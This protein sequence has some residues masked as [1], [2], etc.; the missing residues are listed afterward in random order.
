[1]KKYTISIALTSTIVLLS[2]STAYAAVLPFP[3]FNPNCQSTKGGMICPQTN[4]PATSVPVQT[5]QSFGSIVSTPN[6]VSNQISIPNGSI[7]IERYTDPNTNVVCYY[8]EVVSSTT[9]GI[10]IL[11]NCV[12]VPRS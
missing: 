7:T 2:V 11:S 12:Y 6:P 3:F 10:Q 9:V 5:Q 1:M 8:S 4:E